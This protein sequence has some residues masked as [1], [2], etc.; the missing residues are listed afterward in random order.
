[1]HALNLTKWRAKLALRKFIFTQRVANILGVLPTEV[2]VNGEGF[3]W[4]VRNLYI[5]FIAKHAPS[6]PLYSTVV[7]LVSDHVFTI[8][9]GS[10]LQ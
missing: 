8:F 7:L 4:V 6:L 1:M 2:I 9:S 3:Q 10:V 5:R